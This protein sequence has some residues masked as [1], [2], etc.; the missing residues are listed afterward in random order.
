MH[1]YD[2]DAL[3]LMHTNDIEALLGMHIDGRET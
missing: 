2:T 3:L 1:K